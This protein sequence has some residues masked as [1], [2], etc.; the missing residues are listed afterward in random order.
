MSRRWRA[1]ADDLRAT[2]A[3]RRGA[4]APETALGGWRQH[5]RQKTRVHGRLSLARAARWGCAARPADLRTAPPHHPSV[6]RSAGACRF[7]GDESPRARARG[8]SAPSSGGRRSASTPAHAPPRHRATAWQP[9]AGGDAR[10]PAR[11]RLRV[12]DWATR[13]RTCASSRASAP[14]WSAA[15]RDVG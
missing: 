2:R 3:A 12:P 11:A 5:P 6:G 15:R 4:R 13:G 14:R 9:P 10:R 1:A 8:A 7:A